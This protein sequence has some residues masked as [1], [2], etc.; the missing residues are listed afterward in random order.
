MVFEGAMV[1]LD[2]GKHP[3]P[4]F[5]SSDR[6]GVVHRELKIMPIDGQNEHNNSELSGEWKQSHQT[7]PAVFTE[8]QSLSH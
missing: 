4:D 8:W 2:P 6:S 3:N 7:L 1:S 5:C